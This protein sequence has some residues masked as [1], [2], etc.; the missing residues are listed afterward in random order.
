MA[1]WA[2]PR[3]SCGNKRPTFLLRLG[4]SLWVPCGRLPLIVGVHPACLEKAKGPKV[5]KD[6]VDQEACVLYGFSESYNSFD[7]GKNT[8]LDA[9]VAG[10]TVQCRP[11][12]S[13][14]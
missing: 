13:G 3:Q 2:R 4:T 7:V 12:F 10:L 5:N 9:E 1:F 6:A 11:V 8:E 14:T